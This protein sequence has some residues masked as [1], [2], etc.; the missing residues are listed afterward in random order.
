LLGSGTALA[1]ATTLAGCATLGGNIK[2]DFAC[3]A[4]DGI[5]APTSTI[6]DAA[7][8]LI[9]GDA[10]ASPAGPYTSPRVAPR[11]FQSAVI[12]PVRSNEKVLRIVFPAHIDAAGRYR[13]ATAI[14]AVVARGEWMAAGTAQALP[15]RSS[16]ITPANAV[17]ADAIPN[18]APMRSLGE[19]AAAAPEVGFPDPIADIDTQNASNASSS[20]VAPTKPVAAMTA[21]PLSRQVEAMIT[22]PPLKH[23]PAA[24]LAA[25]APLSVSAMSPVRYSLPPKATV[26]PMDAIKAQVA[27][28]LRTAT[29]VAAQASSGA[30][31]AATAKPVN[32]PALFPASEVNP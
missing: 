9:S 5:C 26:S 11:M 22:A 3:R 19:L 32:G 6:D 1:V 25:S 23:T 2:G 29:P 30:T 28:R 27:A 7:L 12:V 13:E 18:A 16:S 4:P 31:S 8:A 24:P 20:I 14:H 15:V 10:S 17:H 21:K